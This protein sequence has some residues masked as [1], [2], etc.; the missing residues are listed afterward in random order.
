MLET[1]A[2]YDACLSSFDP[3]VLLFASFYLIEIITYKTNKIIKILK[4]IILNKPKLSK[5]I[6]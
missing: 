5:G 1:G 2:C 4:I 6:Q 3:L